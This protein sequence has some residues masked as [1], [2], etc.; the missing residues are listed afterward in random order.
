[1]STADPP[2][3]FAD[4]YDR[5]YD[6]S[7]FLTAQMAF[8]TGLLAGTEGPVLDA[9][10]GTGL[11]VLALRKRGLRSVGLDAD[12]FMLQHARRRL[13][14]AGQPA[15]LIRG[16]LRDLPFHATLDA[17]ICLESPLAYLLTED[18]LGAAL[19][20]FRR[21]L[22]PGGILI[23]DVFD[24][25]GTLGTRGA[26]HVS[27][28]AIPMGRID[29]QERHCYDPATGIW[30]MQQTFAVW[31]EE[32]ET[33]FTICHRLR[34]RSADEYAAALERAGFKIR[35]MLPA[36]PETPVPLKHHRRMIFVAWPDAST[37]AAQPTQPPAPTVAAP[38][39]RPRP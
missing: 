36:F 7:D 19:A 38:A 16:D 2:L 6:D 22:R 32:T 1:M 20:S 11:H 23:A 18:E 4:V 31:R 12:P 9:G 26:R 5:I 8:L 39:D 10:C 34:A 27:T 13:L 21:A 15:A 29:V 33:S 17:I 37:P 35:E 24:Y 28:F 30:E 25:P 14:A 3:T